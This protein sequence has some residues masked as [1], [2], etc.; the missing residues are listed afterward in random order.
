MQTDKFAILAFLNNYESVL[1]T[2]DNG[3]TFITTAPDSEGH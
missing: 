3:V 1:R 2:C